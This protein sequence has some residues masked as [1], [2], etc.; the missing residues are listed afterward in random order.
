MMVIQLQKQTD[1]VL[2]YKC[3]SALNFFLMCLLHAHI[4]VVS[5]RQCFG[6][7]VILLF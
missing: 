7:Y 5:L 1:I 2:A 3:F 4:V 6:Y